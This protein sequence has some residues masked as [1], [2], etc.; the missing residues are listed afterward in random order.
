MEFIVR[1]LSDPAVESRIHSDARL[2]QLWSDPE[3]QR[4]IEELR[5]NSP[6]GVRGDPAHRH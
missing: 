5:R 2:H 4:R 3:V 6:A 1:L